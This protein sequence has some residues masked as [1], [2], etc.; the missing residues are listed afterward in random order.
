MH[1]TGNYT[2]RGVLEDDSSRL[3][4]GVQWL[5][6]WVERKKLKFNF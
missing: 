1:G 6:D 3:Y 4:V 2:I 5:I